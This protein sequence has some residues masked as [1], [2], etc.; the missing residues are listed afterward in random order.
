MNPSPTASHAAAVPVAF[1]LLT[2]LHIVLGELAPKSVALA[3][4]EKT[5]KAV[6]RP[7]VLFSRFMSPFIWL[8]NGAANG[9]LRLF[10]VDPATDEEG[11]SPEEIRFMV[12]Q[13]HARGH[14]R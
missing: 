5:A 4:P 11:H 12:M 3:A 10:G 8:F 13:A 7:L 6:T 2:F 14:T 1:F 9:V